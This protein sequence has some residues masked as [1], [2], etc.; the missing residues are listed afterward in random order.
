M[1]FL[2]MSKRG[3]KWLCAAVVAWGM[4]PAAMWG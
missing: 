4:M 1:N 2:Y 3:H